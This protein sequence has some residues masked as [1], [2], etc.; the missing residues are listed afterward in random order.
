MPSIQSTGYV[1]V[2]GQK[3]KVLA[4]TYFYPNQWGGYVSMKLRKSGKDGQ[5]A[6][7]FG[8]GTSPKSLVFLKMSLSS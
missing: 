1:L 4:R 5:L 8:E 6:R 7:F 2:K 3:I